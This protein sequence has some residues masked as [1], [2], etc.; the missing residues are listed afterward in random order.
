MPTVTGTL[1]TADSAGATLDVPVAVQNTPLAVEV[2]VEPP[3]G[4]P[5]TTF[6]ITARPTGGTPP[7][8]FTMGPIGGV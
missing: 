4:P 6:T 7:Y 1:S 8:R 2:H 3:E 5:G